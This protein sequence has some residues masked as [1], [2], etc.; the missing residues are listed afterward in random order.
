MVKMSKISKL[1]EL[2]KDIIENEDRNG[3]KSLILI[4]AHK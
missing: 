3:Y 4:H 1:R 2:V